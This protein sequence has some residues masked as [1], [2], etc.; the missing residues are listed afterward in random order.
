LL[1]SLKQ[2]VAPCNLQAYPA[3]KRLD[4]EIDLKRS[5]F[6]SFFIGFSNFILKN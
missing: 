5:R 3:L 4:H 1:L 2:K 6:F